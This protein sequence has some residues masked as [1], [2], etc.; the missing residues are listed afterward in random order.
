MSSYSNVKADVFGNIEM[1]YAADAVIATGDIVVLASGYAEE[2]TSATGLTAV[3]ISVSADIDNT[4]GS[5]GDGKVI[6][7][8][9]YPKQGGRRMFWLIND[10]STGA[11]AQADVGSEAYIKDSK[12]VSKTGTSRSKAGLVVAYDAA[13][14]LVGVIFNQFN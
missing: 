3:G 7:E 5:A 10:T 8:T 9:S 2:G 6:V 1:P 4:G 12:T 14:D 11:L 13:K